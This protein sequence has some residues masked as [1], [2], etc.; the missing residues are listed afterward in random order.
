MSGLNE[1]PEVHSVQAETRTAA[2][3][4][5]EDDPEADDP[6]DSL[7]VFDLLRNIKVQVYPLYL[8]T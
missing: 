1:N 6:I 2:E 8:A 3:I 7:E 5:A 4:A